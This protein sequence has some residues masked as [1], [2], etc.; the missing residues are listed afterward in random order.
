MSAYPF[1]H[2]TLREFL[3]IAKSKFGAVQKNNDQP[4]VGPRGHTPMPYL[5]IAKDGEVRIAIIP[6]LGMDEYLVPPKLRSLLS[7]LN[8]PPEEFYL[9]LG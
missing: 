9:P 6:S 4:V 8:L 1:R 2:L 3:E 5:E 7:E